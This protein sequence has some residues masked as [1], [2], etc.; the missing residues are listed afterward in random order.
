[1]QWIA[2]IKALIG[3]V[4]GLLAF[5]RERKLLEAGEALAV[6]KHLKDAQNEIDKGKAARAAILA[7][8]DAHPE[9]LREPDEFQRD[10]KTDS[11]TKRDD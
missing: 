2:V 3:L 5:L 8:L 6:E 1:M 9:R 10:A 4:A 7:E 11:T